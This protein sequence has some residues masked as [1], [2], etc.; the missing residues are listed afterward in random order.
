[1]RRENSAGRSDFIKRDVAAN[2]SAHPNLNEGLTVP[3]NLVP[4]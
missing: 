3:L 1:M 4:R 2:P